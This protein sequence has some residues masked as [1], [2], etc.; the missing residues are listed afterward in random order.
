M[1]DQ[2]GLAAFELLSGLDDDMIVE[3]TLPEGAVAV[4]KAPRRE[5]G[6]FGDFMSSGWAAAILSVVVSLA[7]LMGI[8]AA[9][10]KQPVGPSGTLAGPSADSRAEDETI[11]HIEGEPDEVMVTSGGRTVY[12]KKYTVAYNAMFRDENGELVAVD[13]D[14]EGAAYRLG[15]IKDELP[16]LST[17][18]QGYS[19]HLPEHMALNTIRVFELVSVQ[20]NTFEEIAL[21]AGFESMLDMAESI[22]RREGS[23]IVVLDIFSHEVISEEEYVK[24]WSEYAFW[25]IVDESVK[26]VTPSRITVHSQTLSLDFADR[27][28][29]YMLWD[30]FWYAGGMVS[31]DGFGA[32]GQILE[33]KD[34]LKT[35]SVSEGESVSVILR[36]DNDTLT[37]VAVCGMDGGRVTWGKDCTVLSELAA[38]KYYVILSVRTQGDYVDEAQAYEASCYEYAFILDSLR[39]DPEV[40][41]TEYTRSPLNSQVQ[42]A[43]LTVTVGTNAICPRG[44]VT[45]WF[46]VSRGGG[47][48]TTGKGESA[49]THLDEVEDTVS[50]Y[51]RGAMLIE[52]PENCH[53]RHIGV[54]NMDM[55]LC[56][57]DKR[58][59]IAPE[60]P[61]GEYVVVIEMS[62]EFADGTGEVVEFI[63]RMTIPESRLE[64]VLYIA[65]GGTSFASDGVSGYVRDDSVET[66]KWL[67]DK[68]SDMTLVTLTRGKSFRLVHLT[69]AWEFKSLTLYDSG[70]KEIK[71]YTDNTFQSEF[72][73]LEAQTYYVVATYAVDKLYTTGYERLSVDFPFRLAVQEPVPEIETVPEDTTEPAE[74]TE[75]VEVEVARP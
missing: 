29:G 63:F 45:A 14:G 22:G 68:H 16:R 48:I 50:S 9:G 61:V 15:E 54:Y 3:A 17:D 69:N 39:P 46:D 41:P 62:R 49:L 72:S 74:A 70:C 12:P 43:D 40:D 36:D 38:G 33:I 28:A 10:Q 65:A 67:R 30:E 53:I 58:T 71:T 60:L 64:S 23:Y 26:D 75:P 4:G 32:E 21:P 19:L 13:G 1:T 24:E 7:V 27:S 2:K 25:L 66:A 55:E 52:L 47:T 56:H 6:R 37:G 5:R 59:S 20:D 11:E 73:R 31:G 8:I 35:L 18:G 34:G 44:Y 57:E 42:Y 51:S